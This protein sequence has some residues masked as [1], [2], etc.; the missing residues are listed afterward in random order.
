MKIARIVLCAV[1]LLFGATA[2]TYADHGRPRVSVN[3]SFFYDSL[4]PYGNWYSSP[5]YGWVWAPAS[6]GAS[7]RPYQYGHWA[8]SDYG[9]TWVSDYDWGW[10]TFHYGRWYLDPVLGWVWVPGTE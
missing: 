1:L 8:Y 5:R 10:A 2:A 6:V 9:W 4:A 3:V 7:W